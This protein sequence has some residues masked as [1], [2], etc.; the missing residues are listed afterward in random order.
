[1]LRAVLVFMGRKVEYAVHPRERPQPGI[2]LRYIA[3]N[4][5]IVGTYRTGQ[6]SSYIS[7]C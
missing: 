7:A 2:L 1:M 3:L 6:A 5:H 4:H